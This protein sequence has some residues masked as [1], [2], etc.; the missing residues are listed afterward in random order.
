MIRRPPRSTLFPYTTLFR[1][2]LNVGRGSHK[3]AMGWEAARI[4]LRLSNNSPYGGSSTVSAWDPVHGS[5]A[6]P[7]L[8]A[9]QT[10]TGGTPQALYPEDPRRISNPCLGIAGR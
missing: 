5:W 2:G 8:T 7:H 1:S 6:S 4:N 10:E 9:A 3:I